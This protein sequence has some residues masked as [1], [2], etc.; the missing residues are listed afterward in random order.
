MATSAT[1]QTADAT[2]T[3]EQEIQSRIESLQSNL[4]SYMDSQKT[5]MKDMVSTLGQ[6]Q[7]LFNKAAKSK[8]K[9]RRRVS[10]P[11]QF[12]LDSKVAKKLAKLGL[13]EAQYSRSALM[14]G[15]SAYIREKSLQNPDKKTVWVADSTIAS[16]LGIS[17]GDEKSYL[18]INQ[19]ITPLLEN[20]T[21]VAASE[22]S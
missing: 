3:P 11:Q 2:Q 12:V 19:L 7:K 10:N 13:K 5:V 16:A 4:K 15:I 6:I 14:K 8:N 1:N 21:K 17:K 18:S 20:A 22:S 9:T